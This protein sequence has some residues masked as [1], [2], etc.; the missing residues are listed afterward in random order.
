MSNMVRLLKARRGAFIIM[1]H[2]RK[3]MARNIDEIKDIVNEYMQQEK[4]AV[5]IGAGVSSLSDYPSWSE[6]VLKMA[7]R[8]KYPIALKNLE[9]KECLSSDEYLKIPQIYYDKYGEKEY[10]KFV[11]KELHTFKMP[12]EIHKL[13]MQLKPN[14]I[15]TT[16]Y[17]TLI[18]QTANQL[19][20]SYSV[21]NSD[22]K[23]ATAPTRNY[24]LKV[25][26]D[27]ERNNFVL[28]EC[29][30]LNYE[31]NFKLIDNLM[32]SIISTHLVIFI[33]YGLGD[34]NIKLIMNWV[35]HAQNEGFIEPI[36]I[37]AG[38][39]ELSEIELVYYEGEN[40]QV[41]DANKLEKETSSNPYFD[42]YKASLL[43]LLDPERTEKWYRN[44]TWIIDHFYK[45]IDPLKDMNYLRIND[46]ARLFPGAKI[47]FNEH[48]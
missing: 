5:F 20:V 22:D 4:I 28:K 15:L 14:H 21:I 19:G 26:G 34:Y 8:I 12:N 1:L 17:D 46:V 40:L 41:I 42:N 39:N 13:I 23:V 44:N 32:K 27:F 7:K 6:L 2:G 35:K 9:G 38:L 3:V 16:N 30:Y 47:Y 45:I 33:G 36:F 11:R 31:N 10:L 18:E 43:A 25:H 24:I 29:D 48:R 37:Y